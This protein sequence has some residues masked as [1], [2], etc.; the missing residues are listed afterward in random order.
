MFTQKVSNSSKC[1][2][3]GQ[4]PYYSSIQKSTKSIT[5]ANRPLPK[6]ARKTYKNTIANKKSIEYE[7][8]TN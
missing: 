6:T 1:G 8:Y 7:K 5:L 4:L 2:W 3:K